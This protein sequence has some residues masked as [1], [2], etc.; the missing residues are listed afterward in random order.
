MYVVLEILEQLWGIRKQGEIARVLYCF[1][2]KAN[3][4]N[5]VFSLAPRSRARKVNPE[6]MNIIQFEINS[7]NGKWVYRHWCVKMEME[8]MV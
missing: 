6:V 4:Y 8:G 5:K 1:I 2:F 7:D 3:K